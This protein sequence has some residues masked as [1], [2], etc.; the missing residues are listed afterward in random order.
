MT[1]IIRDPFA[2]SEDEEAEKEALL[3]A[4]KERAEASD[5]INIRI[6]ETRLLRFLPAH[7]IKIVDK[8]YQGRPTGT[9]TNEFVVVDMETNNLKEKTFQVGWNSRKLIEAALNAGHRMLRITRTGEGNETLYTPA[10]V[11]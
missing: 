3:K 6:G 10:P 8:T 4:K 11:H 1:S 7:G 2:N 5:Y 9:K